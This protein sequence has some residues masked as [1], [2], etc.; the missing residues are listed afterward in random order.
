[1]ST[2]E[3]F[4]AM[5]PPWLTTVVSVVPAFGGKSRSAAPTR[6]GSGAGTRAPGVA[7][8]RLPRPGRVG[9]GA[10]VSGTIPST[11]TRAPSGRGRNASRET[12]VVRAA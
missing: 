1:M 5:A 11:T 2:T 6:I 10:G 9:G 4:E 12:R 3:T 8:A 7:T